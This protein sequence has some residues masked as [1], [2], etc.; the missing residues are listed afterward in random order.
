M[1]L[2]ISRLLILVS[3][4][5][6]RSRSSSGVVIVVVVRAI[7]MPVA[8]ITVGEAVVHVRVIMTLELNVPNSLSLEVVLMV[9]RAVVFPGGGFSPAEFRRNEPKFVIDELAF[10]ELVD[11]EVTDGVDWLLLQLSA[12]SRAPVR[13]NTGY[14]PLVD[15]SHSLLALRVSVQSVENVQVFLVH[16]NLLLVRSEFLEEFYE[17]VRTETVHGLSERLAAVHV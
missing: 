11:I 8:V 10:H 12:G 5:S 9:L 7:S 6:C 16:E 4:L 1:L 2:V 13:F 15:D 17:P 3:L 14:V